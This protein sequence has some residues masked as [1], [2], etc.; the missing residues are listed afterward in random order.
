VNYLDN[1]A[2]PLVSICI[3]TYNRAAYLKKSIDSIISQAEFLSG[4]VEIVISDN[5]SADMTKEKVDAYFSKFSNIHY[6]CNS[7]NIGDKNFVLAL[8]R[9]KGVLR[10]LSNDTIV[11]HKESMKCLC[12]LA[13]KYQKEKP[14]LFFTNKRF[15]NSISRCVGLEDFLRCVSYNITWI[16]AL[17]LWDT[18]CDDIENHLEYCSTHLWQVWKICSLLE[19]D[20]VAMVLSKRFGEIQ[21][22]EKKDISYGLYQIFFKNYFEILDA[23]VNKNVISYDCI[24]YLK[25]DLLFNFFTYWIIQWGK[26]NKDY[27]YS[28]DENLK[29]SVFNEYRTKNYFPYY[30]LFFELSKIKYKLKA[31]VKPNV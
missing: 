6:F 17:S 12:T 25:K 7:N 19:N 1:F 5:A 14:L 8:S 20:R 22:V 10:K 29:I 24:E 11:Y 26:N 3:P 18:D 9:G 2:K 31:Y 30:L 4:E 23:F 28:S 13:R 27:K 16:G 21:S 15:S